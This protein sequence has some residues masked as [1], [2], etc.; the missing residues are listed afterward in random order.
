[1]VFFPLRCGLVPICRRLFPRIPAAV[2]K[3][4]VFRA[5]SAGT[6]THKQVNC[7]IIANFYDMRKV[8][9]SSLCLD[10]LHVDADVCRLAE[11]LFQLV[12]N[13]G[14][15]FVGLAEGCVAVHAYM[16][17]DGYAVA[18]TART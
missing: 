11:A 15:T 8:P 12:L 2:G 17:F 14:G 10:G 1:M 3:R 9:L 4:E 16:G 6:T 5:L 7:Y 18:N 13:G